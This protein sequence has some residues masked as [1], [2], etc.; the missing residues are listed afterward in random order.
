[1][2]TLK[3]IIKFLTFLGILIF[4]LNTSSKIFTPKWRSGK[5]QGQTDTI[6]GFYSLP[7]NSIDLLFLGDSSIYKSISPME[8]YEKSGIVSYN[9]SVSS[10]RIYTFYY[11]LQDVL[12]YQKPK[13]VMIDPL[14][15]FYDEKEI[16]PERRKSFDYMRFGK[17]KWNMI[18]ADVY[19]N[20][21]FDKLSYVFPIFRYHDRYNK[22]NSKE[23]KNTFAAQTSPTRGFVVSSRVSPNYNG[24]KYM[25]PNGETVKMKDYTVKY[26]DL[27]IELCKNNN[28][29][30][31]VVGVPDTRAW[32]Y[33]KNEYLKNYLLERKVEYLDLNNE[34]VGINWL[35]DTEDGGMHFN[36]LGAEKITSYITQYL[37]KNYN[38]PDRS[39]DNQINLELEKYN[40]LKKKHKDW[41]LYK[42]KYKKYDST[43]KSNAKKS[44]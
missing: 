25:T 8:V 5:G 13:I 11:L 20:E 30:L 36:I 23:I 15:L 10:A 22:I 16:E 28:I 41:L 1:M 42:I 17:A 19:E 24:F 34:S 26:L 43:K 12:K 38:L 3:N 2:K 33:E 40:K 14:T 9:Y 27:F 39:N 37:V 35:E 29:K 4:L 32:N 31:I 21:T 7:K 18:N 6:S 44:N